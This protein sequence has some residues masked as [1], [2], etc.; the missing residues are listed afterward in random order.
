MIWVS[1]AKEDGESVTKNNMKGEGWDREMG[2]KKIGE[3]K[4]GFGE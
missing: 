1:K 2:E 3:T 4:D